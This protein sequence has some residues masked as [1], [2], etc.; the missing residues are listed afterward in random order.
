MGPAARALEN[1]RWNPPRQPS[2]TKRAH[3]ICL[4]Q[5]F[6]LVAPTG[7]VSDPVSE[8]VMTVLLEIVIMIDVMLPATGFDLCRQLQ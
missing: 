7:A 2:A 3:N 1:K 5:C 8:P 4:L 6:C